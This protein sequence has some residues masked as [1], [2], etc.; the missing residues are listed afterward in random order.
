MSSGIPSEYQ[1]GILDSVDAVTG[2]KPASLQTLGNVGQGSWVCA[3]IAKADD[4]NTGIVKV[5]GQGMSLYPLK[6]V[7][8]SGEFVALDV[9]PGVV[10]DLAKVTIDDL[11]VSGQTV[12]FFFV[13]MSALAGSTR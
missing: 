1:E 3:V 12:H 8:G 7:S 2:G 13:R 5:G 10:I 11:G 6:V 9:P 4:S